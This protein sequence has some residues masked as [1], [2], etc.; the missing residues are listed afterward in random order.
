M[1]IY[2]YIVI[3]VFELVVGVTMYIVLGIKVSWIYLVLTPVGAGKYLILTFT[4]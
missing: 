2:P 1:L 4:A 3:F